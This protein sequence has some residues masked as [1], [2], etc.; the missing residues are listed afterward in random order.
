MSV[1]AP[2]WKICDQNAVTVGPAPATAAWGRAPN[3]SPRYAVREPHIRTSGHAPYVHLSFARTVPPVRHLPASPP[4]SFAIYSES[5]FDARRRAGTVGAFR[6]FRRNRA[7]SP[8]VSGRRD[9]QRF[10][11]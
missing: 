6:C 8:T 4:V 5:A 3:R 10:R 9:V 7:E 11:A 2:A 1:T